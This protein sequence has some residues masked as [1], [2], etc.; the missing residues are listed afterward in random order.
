MDDDEYPGFVRLMFGQA[1]RKVQPPPTGDFAVPVV[2]ESHYQRDIERICGGRTEAGVEHPCEAFLIP[3]HDN[4]YDRHAVRVEVEGRK[5]GYLARPDAKDFRQKYG[6]DP[7]RCAAIVRG[8]WDRGSDD[9][10]HFGVYLD[11]EL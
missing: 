3:E 5:V 2:G 7:R 11:L 1:R 8:G 4:R 10:G 6:S 9:Q